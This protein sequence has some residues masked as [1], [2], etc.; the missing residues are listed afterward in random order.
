MG[1]YCEVGKYA[2]LPF[3]CN[4]RNAA[5]IYQMEQSLWKKFFQF[6]LTFHTLNFKYEFKGWLDWET[7][8]SDRPKTR[9]EFPFPSRTKLSFVVKTWDTCILFPVGWF[10][11]QEVFE[12]SHGRTR[13]SV[14]QTYPIYIKGENNY[15]HKLWHQNA[16]RDEAVLR[17]NTLTSA[18]SRWKLR[19]KGP[20][21]GNY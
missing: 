10:F 11:P 1:C 7:S 5:E 18:W 21:V 20:E 15:I 14:H 17:K 19:L 16:L 13:S 3:L 9:S 4:S 2:L 12:P 6:V 8:Q